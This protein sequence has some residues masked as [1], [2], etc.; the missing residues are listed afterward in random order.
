MAL[1]STA[2]KAFLLVLNVIFFVSRN[3]I[4]IYFVVLKEDRVGADSQTVC[5][6]C[7]NTNYLLRLLCMEY[8]GVNIQLVCTMWR[9]TIYNWLNICLLNFTLIKLVWPVCLVIHFAKIGIQWT[10]FSFWTIISY[11]SIRSIE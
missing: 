9:Q 5:S 7:S 3:F 2:V 10:V 4:H 8:I 11:K 1:P 6:F